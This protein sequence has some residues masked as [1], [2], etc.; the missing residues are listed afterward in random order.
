MRKRPAAVAQQELERC[1]PTEPR[2]LAA[3]Q[4]ASGYCEPRSTILLIAV[5]AQ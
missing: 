1:N 4:T 5:S 2:E 3:L